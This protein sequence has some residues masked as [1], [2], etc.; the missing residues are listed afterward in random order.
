MRHIQINIKG[1]ELSIEKTAL[2]TG[3]S[4]GLGRGFV[5]VL[6]ARG[7]K[8]FASVRE[9]SADLASTFPEVVQIPL[10]LGQSESL[11]EAVKLLGSLTDTIDILVNNAG[12]SSSSKEVGDKSK[13]C[14]LG[15]LNREVLLKMFD[16]NA[17]QPILL[18][19]SL[20]PLLKRDPCYCIQISSARG[21]LYTDE[22]V[23]SSGNYGYRASKAATNMMTR[24]LLHDL[25]SYVR[26]FAVHPGRVKTDMNPSG[27]IFP[28]ESAEKI[29]GILDRWEPSMNGNFLDNE[30]REWAR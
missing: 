30:G 21:A 2:I 3:G 17:V 7:Y 9:H 6:R 15:S 22:T 12:I 28:W 14:T 19:Q 25:P 10:H 5:E 4:R 29:L 13:V 24:A 20:L 16:V 26:T 8:V 27:N 11:N 1:I 23:N 18:I